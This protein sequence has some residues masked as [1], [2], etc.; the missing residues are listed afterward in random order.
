[1]SNISFIKQPDGNFIPP[2]ELVEE[3][4]RLTDFKWR[5]EER[6]AKEDVVKELPKAQEN[7]KT[8]KEVM[9]VKKEKPA[10]RLKS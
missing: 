6:P 7:K 10:K 8:E 4:T 3:N 2:H 9:P 1:V 5:I